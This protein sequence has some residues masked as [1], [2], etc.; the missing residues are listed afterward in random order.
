MVALAG[1]VAAGLLFRMRAGA[2][3]TSAV[4][5]GE[6][7]YVAAMS[8]IRRAAA[9]LKKS[10][11]DMDAWYD[12]P[13]LLADQLVYDDGVDRWY[14]TIYAPRADDNSSVRYG[15]I[16]E[17]AKI[18]I[19]TADEEVLL[20]LPNMTPELVDC[21][22]DYRDSD[23]QVRPHGAEQD[24]YDRLPHPYA[25]KNSRF[26][27]LEELLLVK[28]FDASVIYGEDV[29]FNGMLEDNED[30][31]DD[32]FPSDNRDGIL[33][34]GL[35]GVATTVT[36]GPGD[37]MPFGFPEPDG[38]EDELDE[39]EESE[40]GEGTKEVE[41]E[42]ESTSSDGR[43][44]VGSVNLNTAP[45]EVLAV[46]PGMDENS[47]RRAVAIRDNLDRKTRDRIYW[48]YSYGILSSSS[49]NTLSEWLTTDSYQYRVQCVGFGVPSG[50]FRVL[51]AV[52]DLARG[53]PQITYLRDI[54]RLGVP[55]ELTANQ[56][57]PT[58]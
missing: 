55:I 42:S 44:E 58:Q 54:T 21:L 29:N 11:D 35:R 26:A 40:E 47:A 17:T 32:R 33:N 9:V 30:D 49:L 8:G 39:G 1:M 18:N 56:Q 45:V 27:S 4:S 3:G 31:G 6:Q 25:I 28:G 15:L 10:A 23:S 38:S 34:M 5:T 12:N 22:L 19:N 46:L 7:A 50:R 48:L 16:D 57:E 43:Y 13:E 14:F 36:Y 20:A 53:E 41:E 24:Y 52:I 51:E 2:S 37:Q